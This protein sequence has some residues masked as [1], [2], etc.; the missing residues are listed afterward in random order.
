MWGFVWGFIWLKYWMC[1]FLVCTIF[2]NTSTR[3]EKLRFSIILSSSQF[4]ERVYVCSHC[5]VR[6]C[7]VWRYTKV[8]GDGETVCV[9]VFEWHV[10]KWVS[11]QNCDWNVISTPL[12]LNSI[13]FY[14]HHSLNADR[15]RI[16]EVE[17]RTQSTM[18]WSEEVDEE[19]AGCCDR[20]KDIGERKMKRKLHWS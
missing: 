19:K 10:S 12:A 6:V 16:N 18:E 11:C 1:V 2:Q 5:F 14:Y 20:R 3:T 7:S 13:S 9:C 15:T 17:E 4:V 8:F